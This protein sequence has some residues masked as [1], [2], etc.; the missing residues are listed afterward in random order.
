LPSF[1]TQFNCAY[2]FWKK[3]NKTA[4][5][6]NLNKNNNNNNKRQRKFNWFVIGSKEKSV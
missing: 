4:E 6:H 2:V 5:T 1:I 3:E